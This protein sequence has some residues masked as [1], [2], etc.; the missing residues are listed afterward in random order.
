MRASRLAAFAAVL[1]VATPWLALGCGDESNRGAQVAG[2]DKGVTGSGQNRDRQRKPGGPSLPTT[3]QVKHPHST[4]QVKHQQKAE[5]TPPDRAHRGADRSHHARSPHA[6]RA[7]PPS[8]GGAKTGKVARE[9]RSADGRP[10]LGAAEAAKAARELRTRT[11]RP[12]L[13][14]AEAMKVAR[15]R[16]GA[17]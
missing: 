6:K 17:K 5:R 9:K 2:A 3:T 11:G 1:T 16:R 8:R 15:E 14:S 10:N 4:T 7:E 12:K 13:G